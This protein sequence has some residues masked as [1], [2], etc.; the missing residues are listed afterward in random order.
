MKK[1]LIAALCAVAA[2]TS[3][4]AVGQTAPNFSNDKLPIFDGV[5][6]SLVFAGQSKSCSH[7]PR[8]PSLSALMMWPASTVY[9]APRDHTVIR[10]FTPGGTVYFIG[11]ADP[12]ELASGI[13]RLIVDQVAFAR[14][15]EV[16]TVKALGVCSLMEPDVIDCRAKDAAN[17]TYALRYLVSHRY[18]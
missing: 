10:V 5:C 1:L 16:S 8:D 9:F 15:G 3:F 7:E 12:T 17:R 2:L 11:I 18:Q 4:G 14:S 6:A 13:H